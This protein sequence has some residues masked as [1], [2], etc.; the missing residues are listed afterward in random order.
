MI[1]IQD[2]DLAPFFWLGAPIG[3]TSLC[4]SMELI[5]DRNFCADFLFELKVVSAEISV[6]TCFPLNIWVYIEPCPPWVLPEQ[7]W[8]SENFVH[9]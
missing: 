7:N 3:P 9:H 5:A 2:F 6:Q 4:L 1:D 8:R